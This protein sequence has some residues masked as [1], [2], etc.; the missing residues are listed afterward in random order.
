MPWLCLKV[1]LSRLISSLKYESI[2][3]EEYIYCF[4]C[5]T[6]TWKTKHLENAKKQ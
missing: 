4:R 2:D 1:D 5:N 3:M 6:L